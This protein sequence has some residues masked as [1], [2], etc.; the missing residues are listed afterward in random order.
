[1]IFFKTK[2]NSGNFAEKIALKYLKSKGL[3]KIQ[4][5]YYCR[6]G[7][8]DIIMQDEKELVFVEVRYRENDSHGHAMET[9]NHQK[10][11]KI[12][13][14]S[15]HYMMTNNLGYIPCRIDVVGL[16]GDLNKPSINWIRNIII[17]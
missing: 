7:E 16:H 9:I 15:K 2:R 14:T 8:I 3:K 12:I 11:K 4:S 5:N 13:A 6:Y 17:E 10:L 1:M